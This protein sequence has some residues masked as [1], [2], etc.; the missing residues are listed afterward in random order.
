MLGGDNEVFITSRNW[1]KHAESAVVDGVKVGR[2]L[3][4]R[5]LKAEPTGS[6][7][8]PFDIPVI[9]SNQWEAIIDAREASQS[10]LWHIRERALGD[11][12]IPSLHQ[13]STNYC[14][15][16]GPV[17][18]MLLVRARENQPY[19]RLSATAVA[20]IVKEYR[21]RGGIGIDALR[22]IV[23]NGCPPDDLWPANR[24]DPAL[25][26]PAMRRAAAKNKITEWYD[27][28]PRRF[29]QLAT[30]LLLNIPVAVGYNWWGHEVCA[31][32]LRRY[33]SKWVVDIWNSWGDT[34]GTNGV[35]TLEESQATPDDAVAPIMISA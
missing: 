6:F 12:R 20:A 1:K 24:I 18:A 15:A 17:S 9:P 31:I 5:N 29:D 2:G 26:T 11:G 28:K 22:W 25:D 35:A 32:R 33:K 30:C 4:P 3:K 8:A 21:N 34:Y 14:W 23:A 16:H 19:V 7:A 13:G 10:S 27:L